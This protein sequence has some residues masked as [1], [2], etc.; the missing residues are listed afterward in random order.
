M[1]ARYLCLLLPLVLSCRNNGEKELVEREFHVSNLVI[2]HKDG[3]LPR[4][5]LTWDKGDRIAIFDAE[6]VVRPFTVNASSADGA[7]LGGSALDLPPAWPWTALHPF[8]EGT[9]YG[10]RF[11]HTE[12]PVRQFARGAS[13]VGSA[14]LAIAVSKETDFSFI[15]LGAVLKITVPEKVTTLKSVTIRSADG[16]PL[17]GKCKIEVIDK[18]ATLRPEADGTSDEIILSGE[19]GNLLPGDYYVSMF[20]GVRNLTFSFLS[21]SGAEEVF[22]GTV[23]SAGTSSRYE[24]AAVVTA[25][26]FR[27]KKTVTVSLSC[28]DPSW[29]WPD[30]SKV[31]AWADADAAQEYTVGEDGSFS[32]KVRPSASTLYVKYH[33]AEAAGDGVQRLSGGKFNV[34]NLP[35]EA[36]AAIPEDG[37]VLVTFTPDRVALTLADIDMSGLESVTV[38]CDGQ[39]YAFVPDE[40]GPVVIAVP[41]GTYQAV[42]SI[43]RHNEQ[44]KWSANWDWSDSACVFCRYS[45]SDA[46]SYGRNL[47]VRAGGD[48]GAAI[49]SATPGKDAVLVGE[50]TFNGPFKMKEGVDVTGGYDPLFVVSAPDVYRTILSGGGQVLCQETDFTTVTVWKGFTITGGNVTASSVNGGGAQIKAGGIL[51][52]C[53]ITGNVNTVKG[54]VAGGVYVALGGICRN[55]YIHHNE[56]YSG[57]GAFVNGCITGCVVEDNL[58][59][60]YAGGIG[61]YNRTSLQPRAEISNCL[62][63]NN[64]TTGA[65]GG[66]RTE[67]FVLVYNCLVTGNSAG[68]IGGGYY[69]HGVSNTHITDVINCTFVNNSSA[70]EGGAGL[71]FADNSFGSVLNCVVWANTSA[72]TDGL[73]IKSNSRW[74]FFHHNAFPANSLS[75]PSNYDA[76]RQVG[77]VTLPA[78][79]AGVFNSDWA[80]APGSPLVD[81]GAD[82]VVDSNAE[83]VSSGIIPGTPST[84]LAGKPRRSGTIDIGCYESQQ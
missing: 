65:G 83:S 4:A 64:Q 28:T 62:V 1:K 69:S 15:P 48:L 40:S 6:R 35:F 49:A 55:C 32:M 75:V 2:E 63:R 61:A 8:V 33:S 47:L 27:D 70:V 68:G 66:L 43:S 51:E 71:C 72:G 17:S 24:E 30:G 41:R 44:S 77:T 58:S 80:P 54:N 26:L 60:N 25:D 23:R 45:M 42:I 31:S 34:E 14:L 38:T 52:D 11:I 50:G 19:G 10:G 29:I 22:D 7:S 37:P 16:L 12:I 67:G 73:Q 82:R 78:D 79:G 39:G 36:E 56:G 13:S 46:V 81:A 84:D 18:T 59:S 76:P 3:T 5:V 74:R 9:T 21:D 53:E 20:S 57:G